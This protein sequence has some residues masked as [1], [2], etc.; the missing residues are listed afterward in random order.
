MRNTLKR[1]SAQT[2]ALE[3]LQKEH[4]RASPGTPSLELRRQRA[5]LQEKVCPSSPPPPSHP[6]VTTTQVRDLTQRMNNMIL[7]PEWL[8][9]ISPAALRVWTS[10]KGT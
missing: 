9:K 10:R 1:I 8:E 4:Q 2:A 5:T 6:F 3:R 7:L